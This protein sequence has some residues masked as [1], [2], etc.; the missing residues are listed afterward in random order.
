MK[1]IKKIVHS[2]KIAKS[3]FTLIENPTQALTPTPTCP[4]N[5]R[6]NSGAKRDKVEACVV[7]TNESKYNTDAQKHRYIA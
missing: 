2:T 3:V 1:A 5:N 6:H 4:H 7:H